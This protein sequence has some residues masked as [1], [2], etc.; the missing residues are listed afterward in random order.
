MVC[1]AVNGSVNVANTHGRK[2]HQ[3]TR[4]NLKRRNVGSVVIN[5]VK[6]TIRI[7]E[8][9]HFRKKENKK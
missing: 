5:N 6:T 1:G 8:S 4:L 2:D 9:F 3:R 7:M